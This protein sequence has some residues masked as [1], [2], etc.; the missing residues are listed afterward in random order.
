[1]PI[2]YS[3]AQSD[4]E[5]ELEAKRKA[6]EA[7][8]AELR[9]DQEKLDIISKQKNTLDK[10]VKELDFTGKK[11]STE[12]SLTQSKINETDST[13]KNLERN[14]GEKERRIEIF[15]ETISDGIRT[16]NDNDSKP[17]LLYILS[18]ESISGAILETDNRISLHKNIGAAIRNLD[19]EKELLNIDK[20]EH[21]TKK[22]ELEDYKGEV[23]GQKNE[24]DKN[25]KEKTVLLS[26]TKQSEAS[27][28]KII[29]EKLRLQKQFEDEL[30]DIESK[31][32]FNL[33]PNSYPKPKNGILAW[34]LEHVLITQGFGLTES[35]AK[36][37]GY[38]K[39]IWT[40]K[41]AGIDF[42]A[43]NDR[44][45]AMADG[46]VA[47]V[48]NTDSVCPKASTG[49]WILIKYDNG[50]AG[51]FFHLSSVVVKKGQR[52]KTGDLVAYSGNTG[53]ST[54]PHLHVGIAPAGVTS[55]ETW[56]SAA[57]PGKNY[58]SPVVANSFYL[59]PLDYFP[60]PSNDMW[61][62]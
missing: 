29:E 26:E 53:Y 25:K 22:V 18:Q 35:S 59:N 12:V 30:A 7:L 44:V 58:T 52:V 38:R 55:V 9:Q 2:S 14:I 5:A 42:R 40:G 27:Y 1:M 37:Y 32:K 15:K 19:Q 21:Q 31:I 60:K 13:I 49:V 50:L 46:T 45:L 8:E 33:D 11:L 24:V 56:P 4:L 57:C 20:D 23:I 3:F 6:K 39:G 43:N 54:A 41:H 51:T 16:I 62:Q 34:P 48:G 17:F 36:L 10:A 28:Q 47:G 61:K